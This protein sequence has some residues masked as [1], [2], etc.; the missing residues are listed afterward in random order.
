[1]SKKVFF[2]TNNNAL[3]QFGLK[4][5]KLVSSYN[6]TRD[7]INA[8]RGIKATSG[9]EPLQDLTKFTDGSLLD[10]YFANPQQNAQQAAFLSQSLY[11]TNLIYKTII[12]YF[13]TMYYC[14]Y[15]TVPRRIKDGKKP[16]KKEYQE[17]YQEMLELVDGINLE[18]T[19][20]TILLNIFRDGGAYLYARG[21]RSSKTISTIIL[22]VKYCRPGVKT[23]HGTVIVDFDFSFFDSFGLSEEEKIE[24]LSMF[25]EEFVEKYDIYRANTS[26]KRWQTLNPKLSTYI[27][28]NDAGFPSLLSVFYD[29]IDY[30]TYKLNEL[31]KSTNKL[32]RL[33]SQEIDL[34]KTGL[35]L[36]EVEFLHDS[37]AG[38]ICENKGTTLVTTVG[39][40]AVHQL[41]EDE[42]VKNEALAEAY[43]SV[44]SNAGLNYN[45]FNGSIAESLDVSSKKD[46]TLVWNFIEKIMSFYNLA[47][48]NIKNFKSF[49]LSL[50]FLPIS[51]YNAKEELQ[52]YHSNAEYGVG[53]LDFVVASGIKQIDLDA[54][55]ELEEYLDLQTRLVPLSS[56]HTTSSTDIENK[57][58]ENEK[59][60]E[61]K[62]PEKT[63]E[64]N[65][66]TDENDDKKS[67]DSNIKE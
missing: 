48:N 46:H 19:V 67:Q 43:N 53:L 66:T 14:R 32:E 24:L 28:M 38:A 59:P 64:E 62:T 1:M 27:P 42:G 50:R 13:C 16:T 51:A 30:K 10:P 33:V 37:M 58:I 49:Q 29:I 47:I 55:L 40:L 11:N 2:R 12:D 56:S 54:T 61:N 57:K 15:V 26:S 31:D 6:G 3:E 52:N 17:I 21:D 44:F 39:K 36:P 18:I 4:R 41:Q 65:K 45:L 34:E 5:K 63:S 60:E 20:P 23:Q 8:I 35:E 7:T 9:R 25:P 22:P